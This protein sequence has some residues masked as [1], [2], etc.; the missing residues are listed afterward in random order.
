[1][2]TYLESK[3]FIL[4]L[5]LIKTKVAI[6]I[7]LGSFFLIACSKL[8]VPAQPVPFTFQDLGVFLLA[9]TQ[10]GK[11][12]GYATLLY[13]I[14]ATMG[15]PVLAF[16]SDPLWMLGPRAGYL[17]SF[18]LA[19]WVVGTLLEKKESP[20]ILKQTGTI[21]SGLTIIYSFGA[22]FL[23]RFTGLKTSIY[24]GILPF[25]PF[26]IVKLFL[27]CYSSKY[28]KQ[29]KSILEVKKI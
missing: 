10:G 3:S 8:S 29:L 16:G 12:A 17:L 1:M 28:V 13:L 25:L 20:S 15:M 7:I 23:A 2:N 27:I 21:V 18:P 24:V 4:K 26:A 19:A 11:K 5:F 6:E 9:M 14:W 22:L